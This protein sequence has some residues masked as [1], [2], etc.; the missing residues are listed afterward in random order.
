MEIDKLLWSATRN[1]PPVK[2][3]YKDNKKH[4]KYDKNAKP[5]WYLQ[6]NV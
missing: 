2:L 3:T 4:R 5:L 1:P 6:K